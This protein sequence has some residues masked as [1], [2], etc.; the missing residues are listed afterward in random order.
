MRFLTSS[1]LVFALGALPGSS[2]WAQSVISAHSGLVHYVEGRV[3][4]GDKEI[5]PKVGEFPEIKNNQVLKAEE[6]RAEVLLSPGVFLRVAENSSIRMLSNRLAD[7]RVEVLSGRAMVECADV[8]KEN[9]V[10]L[11]VGGDSVRLLKNGLYEFFG[12]PAGVRVFQGEAAVES[13]NGQVTIHKGHEATLTA[14]ID[15]HK[16]NTASTDDLYN[17]SSRRSGYVAAANLSAAKQMASGYG[18]SGYGYGYGYNPFGYGYGYGNAYGYGY[19]FGMGM[20]MMGMGMGMGM[21]GWAWNPL[22][23]MFTYVPYDGM[24]MNPFGYS[25]FSPYTVGYALPAYYGG[26][27]SGRTLSA[28]GRGASHGGGSLGSRGSRGR[29]AGP[30]SAPYRTSSAAMI[31]RSAGNAARSNIG[32]G[33][34]R[35]GGGWNGG[36][37]RGW[38]GGGSLSSTTSSVSSLPAASVGGGAAHGSGGGAHR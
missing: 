1:C 5:D 11:Q 4:L 33:M 28:G 2:A 22:F 20:G 6:G 37:G 7:T 29:Y 35:G 19:P 23:G 32:G 25:F 26:T 31:S 10:T 14:V 24:Y 38:T 18:S 12:N 3:L 27:G 36:G 21:N 17:W 13:P 34:S 30:A 9:L 15:E 8:M 16:F